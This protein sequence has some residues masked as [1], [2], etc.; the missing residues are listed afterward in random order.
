M[1]REYTTEELLK[2]LEADKPK[3][4]ALAKEDFEKRQVAQVKAI[5]ISDAVNFI[6]S[7]GLK[8]GKCKISNAN[9][10]SAYC[11]WSASPI[12]KQSFFCYFSKHFTTHHERN[13]RFYYLNYTLNTLQKKIMQVTQHEPPK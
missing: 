2:L 13:F 7:L 5:E 10:Y 12:S 8:D 11:K 9:I 1:E 6:I 4:I 3:E